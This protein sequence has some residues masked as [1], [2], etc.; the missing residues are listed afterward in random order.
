MSN[1]G[2]GGLNVY[3]AEISTEVTLAEEILYLEIISWAH[4]SVEYPVKKGRAA[5]FHWPEP[6]HH[7]A[8]SI[9]GHSV[10]EAAFSWQI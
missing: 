3:L 10:V 9:E 7:V 1:V 2:R 5:W 4:Q 6:T 8:E